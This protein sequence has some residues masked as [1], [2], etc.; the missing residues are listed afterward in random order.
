MLHYLKSLQEAYVFYLLLKVSQRLTRFLFS[1]DIQSHFVVFHQVSLDL[2]Q[3]NSAKHVT[4]VTF[5]FFST[6]NSIQ[7][8]AKWKGQ[9]S[10]SSH[11]LSFTNDKAV[12]YFKHHCSLRFICDFFICIVLQ[13]YRADY[14]IKIF[15]QKLSI[16]LLRFYVSILCFG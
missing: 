11:N 6:L 12:C 3:W 7:I 13:K 15:S 9:L 4:L 8:K 1:L 10:Y 5:F 16:L 2:S 14:L